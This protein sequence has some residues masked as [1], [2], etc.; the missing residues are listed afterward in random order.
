MS[1][2]TQAEFRW[3]KSNPEKW[4]QAKREVAE[5]ILKAPRSDV[6]VTLINESR[7]FRCET[8]DLPRVAEVRG[9]PMDILK[10]IVL[11]WLESDKASWFSLQNKS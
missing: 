8:C 6:N 10:E 4:L 3:Y 9:I 5:S 7:E 2:R 1:F 11:E